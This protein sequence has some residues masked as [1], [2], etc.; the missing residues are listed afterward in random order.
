MVISRFACHRFIA[1]TTRM[2]LTRFAAAVMNV[3]ATPTRASSTALWPCTN[4][5]V[6]A[7][8][9]GCDTGPQTSR[10][11]DIKQSPRPTGSQ[12]DLASAAGPYEAARVTS[13]SWIGVERHQVHLP[14]L[15]WTEQNL[16]GATIGFLLAGFKWGFL[17]LTNH[18]VILR[19][20]KTRLESEQEPPFRG[21][22]RAQCLLELCSRTSLRTN[23]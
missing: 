3:T 23:S 7:M 19:L 9:I 11:G 6:A 18:I 17:C 20:E 1:T 15:R 12:A 10:N 13:D 14:L 8:P 21:T 5:D 22:K 16:P 4:A 2:Q